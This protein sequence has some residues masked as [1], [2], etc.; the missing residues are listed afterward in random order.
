MNQQP[1]KITEIA[2]HDRRVIASCAY[3]MGH[4]YVKTLGANSVVHACPI[5]GGKDFHKMVDNKFDLKK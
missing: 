3:C 5:C 2:S 4:G 1:K